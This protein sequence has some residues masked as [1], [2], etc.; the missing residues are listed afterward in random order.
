MVKLVR[1]VEPDPDQSRK[2]VGMKTRSRSKSVAN[3]ETYI[4]AKRSSRAKSTPSHY[5]ETNISQASGSKPLKRRRLSDTNS[6]DCNKN[7]NK[8]KK[9][10]SDDVSEQVVIMN[11]KL[12]NEVLKLKNLML[13]KTNDFINLREQYHQ[14]VVEC[15]SLETSLAEAKKE[16]QK[17]SEIY[18]VLKAEPFCSD[19]IKFE[20]GGDDNSKKSNGTYVMINRLHE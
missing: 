2:A 12:M 11:C 15:I 16:N 10:T 7:E 9:V 4:P 14:K 18:E 1:I 3:S 6:T 19:L 20:D 5:V 13:E 17:L 8:K